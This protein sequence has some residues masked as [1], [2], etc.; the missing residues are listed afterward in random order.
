MNK[1]HSQLLEC[2]MFLFIHIIT[3][4]IVHT[5]ENIDY[6]MK[7]GL[8]IH[9]LNSDCKMHVVHIKCLKAQTYLLQNEADVL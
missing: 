8:P 3:T 1:I 9:T 4:I 5:T 6:K 2:F 7:F